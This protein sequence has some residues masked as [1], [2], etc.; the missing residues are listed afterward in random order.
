LAKSSSNNLT[1][2]L[3]QSL[4]TKMNIAKGKT[5]GQ[6]KSA[7]KSLQQTLQEAGKLPPFKPKILSYEKILERENNNNPYQNA[8]LYMALSMAKSNN[9]EQK[10][11]LLEALEFLKK[12]NQTEET[13]ANLALDNAVYIKAARHFHEYFNRS[14]DQVHPFGLLA[15]AQYIKKSIVPAK[16]IMICRTSNSITM[17]LPFFKPLTEYKAWRDISAVALYGKP[18]G[19]GVAVSLNNTDYEG[20]G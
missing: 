4:N 18:S 3:S 8:L 19:S 16:P 7:L 20:T 15:K 2:N 5:L 12:A 1:K 17:K 9:V 10:S 13:L 14:P 11:L 6:N